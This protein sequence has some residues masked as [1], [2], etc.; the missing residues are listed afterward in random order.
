M[1]KTKY[2]EVNTINLRVAYQKARELDKNL[3]DLIP[4]FDPLAPTTLQVYQDAIINLA[5][6]VAE[7]E[8]EWC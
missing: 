1:Y 2:S 3:P 6:R 8:L 4:P 7:L 5:R